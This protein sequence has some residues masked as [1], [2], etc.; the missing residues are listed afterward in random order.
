ML[1]FGSKQR[2]EQK[3]EQKEFLGVGFGVE[4]E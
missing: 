2:A 3:V 1:C 4:I